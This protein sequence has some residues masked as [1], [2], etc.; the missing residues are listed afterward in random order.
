MKFEFEIWFKEF[1]YKVCIQPF[2]YVWENLKFS[3][4][5]HVTNFKIE[6][7]EESCTLCVSSWSWFLWTKIKII[8]I[9]ASSK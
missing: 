5:H 9:L 4:M 8:E 7:N 2:N 3:H 1:I 6:A